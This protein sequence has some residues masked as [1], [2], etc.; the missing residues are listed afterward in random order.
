[1]FHSRYQLSGGWASAE[2]SRLGLS[3]TNWKVIQYLN[4]RI[5]QVQVRA[6]LDSLTRA[7]F[8]V[9]RVFTG[10]SFG[11]KRHGWGQTGAYWV[12][13]NCNCLWQEGSAWLEPLCIFVWLLNSFMGK[14]R[15]GTLSARRA[16]AR[17]GTQSVSHLVVDLWVELKLTAKRKCCW[18]KFWE[19]FVAGPQNFCLVAIIIHRRF[20]F[21]FWLYVVSTE[22][23]V[24]TLAIKLKVSTFIVANLKV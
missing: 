18:D 17:L 15:P 23:L 8:T 13:G 14:Q 3:C 5:D 1:M 19:R 7:P 22:N 21:F 9:S 4:I 16:T 11:F 2:P 12:S 24:E 10:A 20:F 6:G